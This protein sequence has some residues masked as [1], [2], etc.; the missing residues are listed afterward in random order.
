M[1][2]NLTGIVTKVQGR[3]RD[4]RYSSTEIRDYINDAQNDVFNEYPTLR[5]MKTSQ[6]YTVAIGVSDITNGAGLP[7]NCGE[8][9]DLVD[10]T[11]GGEQ[12]ITYMDQTELDRLYPDNQDTSLYP[13]GRPLYW[14]WDE[15]VIK[16]FPAPAAAYVFKLKFYKIATILVADADV[17]DLPASFE[18]LLVSGG[19]YR[20]LQVKDQYDQAGIHQNKYDEIL[21]K[22]VM[23]YA[24]PQIGRPTT[25][26]INRHSTMRKSTTRW[27]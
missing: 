1:A 25:M 17:P 16:V 10:T 14:F 23:R 6:P 19:S 27:R 9:I 4:P 18:E 21:Q 11:N 13:N 7:T 24:L 5:F 26:R 12:V 15:D 8:V 3:V 22:L 20:V 2:Y